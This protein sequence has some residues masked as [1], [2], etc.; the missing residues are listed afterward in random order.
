MTLIGANFC[1]FSVCTKDFLLR[2]IV[3]DVEYTTIEFAIIEGITRVWMN[4]RETSL[5]DTEHDVLGTLDY[6][7]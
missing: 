5:L 6:G 7:L 2:H 3:G 1:P 4:I